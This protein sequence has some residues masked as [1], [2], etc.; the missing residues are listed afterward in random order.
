[1]PKGIIQ[2]PKTVSVHNQSFKQADDVVAAKNDMETN[3]GIIDLSLDTDIKN[4]AF[5]PALSPE[6]IDE[7]SALS[8]ASDPESDL[9]DDDTLQLA[10][11]MGMQMEEDSEHPEEVDLARDINKAEEFIRE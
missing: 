7:Q 8:S 9:S 2:T 4:L 1:M 3:N 6:E 11:N 5:A 10:Q